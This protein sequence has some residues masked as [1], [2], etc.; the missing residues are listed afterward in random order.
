MYTHADSMCPVCISSISIPECAATACPSFPGTDDMM[1][2]QLISSPRKLI[3]CFFVVFCWILNSYLPYIMT[4]KQM[5]QIVMSL[6]PTLYYTS[7]DVAWGVGNEMSW[8]LRDEVAWNATTS[9]VPRELHET[10]GNSTLSQSLTSMPN[11]KEEQ[12]KQ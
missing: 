12:H 8:E 11:W 1:S 6:L 5:F 4:T 9:S 10:G 2:S 3:C 7:D